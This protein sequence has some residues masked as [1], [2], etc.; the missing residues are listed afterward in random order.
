MIQFRYWALFQFRGGTD[1]TVNK[2]TIETL[3]NPQ[4]PQIPS[5]IPNSP[6]KTFKT[7]LRY[8][9]VIH[10][11]LP[12][13]WKSTRYYKQTTED[14]TFALRSMN[15]AM[16]RKTRASIRAIWIKRA[17]HVEVREDYGVKASGRRTQQSSN[18]RTR[19]RSHRQA[20]SKV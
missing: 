4:N 5:N 1:G 16:A 12:R 8:L 7:H 19:Q 3:K 17:L 18:A 15:N 2:F 6:S 9:A 11:M 13:K 20:A 14:V 10:Y